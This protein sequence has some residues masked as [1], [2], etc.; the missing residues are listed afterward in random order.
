[1]IDRACSPKSLRHGFTLVELLVTISIIALLL[2]IFLPSLRRAR[3]QAKILVCQADMANVNK[4]LLAYFLDLD[5]IPILITRG[6]GGEDDFGYCSWS[7]GGWTGK[8]KEYYSVYADGKFYIPTPDR[9]LNPYMY[10]SSSLAEETELPVFRCPSDRQSWQGNQLKYLVQDQRMIPIGQTKYSAYDD[11]GTSFHINWFWWRPTS[12]GMA[13]L[14]N[15]DPDQSAVLQYFERELERGRNVWRKYS[16]R[17]A[18]R[19]VTLVED[20]ADAC[21]RRLPHLQTRTVGIHK[22]FSKYNFSFLDGHVSYL[23]A[24]TR[25]DWGPEWTVNDENPT[26]DSLLLP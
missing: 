17:G 5:A 24:D 11:V 18:S 8:N 13:Y 22:Q 7:Y 3:E 12:E 4:S 6:V 10:P 19:F 16:R 1:M 25:N 21:L 26:P 14:V 15:P 9:P 2:A 20:P 23:Y